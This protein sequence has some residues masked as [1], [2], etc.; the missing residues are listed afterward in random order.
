MQF[1]VIPK[2]VY[3]GTASS[4]GETELNAFDN[5]LLKLGIGDVSLVKITSILPSD[6]EIVDNIEK[7]PDGM[8]VPAIYTYK[9]SSKPD[10]VI[11]AAI[12]I[13]KTD[14]GPTLVAEFSAEGVDAEKAEDEAAKRLYLMAKARGLK[15][16]TTEVYSVD[17]KV[18]NI[19]CVL[20]AV[21]ELE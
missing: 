16:A 5:C 21:V 1:V 20:A 9:I 13:G 11:A 3:V 12:A 14:K 18:E 8:N 19:G 10:S 6:V 15:L 4:E 17:H 7:L 2:K